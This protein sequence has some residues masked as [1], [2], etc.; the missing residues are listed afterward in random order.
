MNMSIQQ[1][2][3]V[4]R[5]AHRKIEECAGPSSGVMQKLA[6]TEALGVALT[7][8]LDEA[9]SMIN[10]VRSSGIEP[11][12]L[13]VVVGRAQE[14]VRTQRELAAE[15]AKIKEAQRQQMPRIAA[16]LNT[17]KEVTG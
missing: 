14:I 16:L 8:A 4:L 13:P 17:L 1:A 11:A 15:V 9:V 6:E 3:G 5:N 2:Q 10:S 7:A 12:K